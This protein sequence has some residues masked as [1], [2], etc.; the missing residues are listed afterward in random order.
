MISV[1][2]DS[3]FATYKVKEQML[4]KRVRCKS[5]GEYFTISDSAEDEE[6]PAAAMPGKRKRPTRAR[7]SNGRRSKEKKTPTLVY[8]VIGGGGLLAVSLVAV[9]AV[10]LSGPADTGSPDSLASSGAAP[11]GGESQLVTWSVPMGHDSDVV[12]LVRFIPN[13]DRLLSLADKGISTWSLSELPVNHSRHIR[14][15][16]VS[17]A[18]GNKY[19]GSLSSCGRVFARAES[20][21]EKKGLTVRNTANGEEVLKVPEYQ[22]PVSAAQIA[23]SQ[24]GN[25][26]AVHNNQTRD[27]GFLLLFDANSKQEL[28]RLPSQPGFEFAVS[29]NGSLA[30]T[31]FQ[32]ADTGAGSLT[33]WD[34]A[35]ST[36]LQ[37]MQVPDGR[38]SIA[39]VAFAGNG[40]RL[41]AATAAKSN[42]SPSVSANIYVW[43][44]TN[45]ALL[46][47][48]ENCLAT[49]GAMQF[50]GEIR[51]AAFHISPDQQH[52]AFCTGNHSVHIWNINTI[53]QVGALQYIG[54]RSAADWIS[55]PHAIRV[56]PDGRT[57]AM[58][59]NSKTLEL[60]DIAAGA[61][62]HR[63]SAHNSPITSLA[64]SEDGGRVASGCFRG[65]VSVWDVSTGTDAAGSSLNTRVTAIEFSPDGQL[66][67]TLGSDGEVRLWDRHTGALLHREIFEDPKRAASIAFS[68]DG[69]TLAVG[70]GYM[71]ILRQKNELQG[72]GSVELFDVTDAKGLA[73]RQPPIEGFESTVRAVEFSPDGNQ[74]V[75]ASPGRLVLVDA[76]SGDIQ[77]ECDTPEFDVT[78]FLMQ[79][80]T[81]LVDNVT[82][83]Q[84]L[85]SIEYTPPPVATVEPY[86]WRLA[87]SFAPSGEQFAFADGYRQPTL[88]DT[89]S[90]K[91]TDT[92]ECSYRVWGVAYTPNGDAVA[93]WGPKKDARKTSLG[94]TYGVPEAF[95]LQTKAFEPLPIGR[96]AQSGLQWPWHNQVTFS[97]DGRFVSLTS[98]AAR[99]YNLSV[100]EDKRHII[101][102]PDLGFTTDLVDGEYYGVAAFSP[103]SSFIALGGNGRLFVTNVL[104]NT[105][106]DLRSLLSANR[107]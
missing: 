93:V 54:D 60:W 24:D 28:A 16:D 97:P 92:I 55:T 80:D 22:W 91:V 84:Q 5:C 101:V 67:A 86:S 94:T 31:Q 106:N 12:R 69:S 52:L 96:D 95:N 88:W 38:R 107:Q 73:R 34:I 41:V 2:C 103:D 83:G 63:I 45:G 78:T 44:V 21:G 46:Q 49:R 3:C 104:A 14:F 102:G 7:K 62:L 20:N 89:A 90:G 105:K 11:S 58:V 53:T 27:N 25:I 43:D 15:E 36:A 30:A 82:R 76:K 8:L 56:S 40:T 1:Q 17:Y 18:G 79:L 98:H 47:S 23:L 13:E 81:L 35:S 68:N 64:F 6:L 37:Q 85:T 48:W 19:E 61:Q 9:V 29:A 42:S 100:A 50:A 66:L 32:N 65:D 26:L 10:L 51:Q 59:R 72:E 33:L 70:I 87:V 71:H 77:T 99:I 74:L 75:A 39:W 57:M 4:G